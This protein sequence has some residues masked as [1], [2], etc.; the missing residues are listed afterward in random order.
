[1][2]DKRAEAA[3]ARARAAEAR[4]KTQAVEAEARAQAAA[5]RAQAAAVE[6]DPERSVV[7]WLLQLKI[8]PN[9]ARRAAAYCE[10]IPAAPLEQR[11]KM[12]LGYLA[13]SRGRVVK[14]L[15]TAA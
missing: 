13:T 4:A 9:D 5:E 3:A 1:M 10:S 11:V 6:Q 15:G 2:S 12:A 14:P 8:R 7:P